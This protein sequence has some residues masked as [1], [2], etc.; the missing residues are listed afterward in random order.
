MQQWRL[1]PEA[2]AFA[3]MVAVK[4]A[5]KLRE[6]TRTNFVAPTP[7]G[8]NE[9]YLGSNFKKDPKRVPT[10]RFYNL[11][12]NIMTNGTDFEENQSELVHLVYAHPYPKVRI[13]K[14][15]ESKNEV[16]TSLSHKVSLKRL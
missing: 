12:K 4:S 1:L 9:N 7:W 3:S 8:S 15:L 16:S 6:V 2:S 10:P 13:S 11:S 5:Q 14:V